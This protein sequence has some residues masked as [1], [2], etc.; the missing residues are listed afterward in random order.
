MAAIPILQLFGLPFKLDVAHQLH[1]HYRC[2][3]NFSRYQLSRLYRGRNLHIQFY[4]VQN[5]TLSLPPRRAPAF[6]AE[7][8]PSTRLAWQVGKSF[9]WQ[10]HKSISPQ[11]IQ[12]LTCI[13]PDPNRHLSNGLFSNIIK[14]DASLEQA[15]GDRPAFNT[16][17]E[18]QEGSTSRMT[19][20]SRHYGQ[21]KRE[22]YCN[23]RESVPSPE[24]IHLDYG[25]LIQSRS[26]PFRRGPPKAFAAA[27]G[28]STSFPE[29]AGLPSAHAK[30][31]ISLDH[32]DLTASAFAHS[33][34]KAVD[35]QTRP[36][37]GKTGWN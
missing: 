33:I 30:P 24:T 17:R 26:S 15:L 25:V 8:R 5:A 13:S 4:I 36:F 16:P 3:T 34:T 21:H 27:F 19:T 35:L 28:A 14:T 22:Y 31:S 12:T 32:T 20:L 6:Q 9:A 23:H 1:T 7:D 2:G 18:K 37:T 11:I 29:S 10:H